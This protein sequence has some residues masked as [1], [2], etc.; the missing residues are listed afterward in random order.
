MLIEIDRDVVTGQLLHGWSHR[1]Y[2]RCIRSTLTT[3][4]PARFNQ[5]AL[6]YIQVLIPDS[7]FDL[8]LRRLGDVGGL[9]PIYHKDTAT[10]LSLNRVTV[11]YGGFP[12]ECRVQWFE[13]YY[14]AQYIHIATDRVIEGTVQHGWH[15]WKRGKGDDIYVTPHT[16]MKYMQPAALHI[17][18]CVVNARLTS[19]FVARCLETSPGQPVS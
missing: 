2:W 10:G 7:S 8:R 3:I 1:L 9:P 13:T 16:F 18:R 17:C 12:R 15:P 14:G 11:H 19:D 5:Q 4:M 6:V